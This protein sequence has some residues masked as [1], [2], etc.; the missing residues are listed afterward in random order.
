MLKRPGYLHVCTQK[1][2]RKHDSILNTE[3]DHWT[4]NR[5]AAVVV[6][7]A[8]AAAA[9]AAVAAAAAA[10]AD[11]AVTAAAAVTATAPVA[12]AGD[13]AGGGS[14]RQHVGPNSHAG[15]RARGRLPR[16]YRSIRNPAALH[17]PELG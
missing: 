1:G 14:R 11:A 16:R 10:A 15:S 3:A 13:G 8:A 2:E 17:E 12:A 5:P 7:R 9:T 4:N 6:V